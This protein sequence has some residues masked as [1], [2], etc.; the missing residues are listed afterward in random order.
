M[1]RDGFG[2]LVALRTRQWAS[3]ENRERQG[4]SEHFPRVRAV[5]ILIVAC[6]QHWPETARA[7]RALRGGRRTEFPPDRRACRA[8][9][10]AGALVAI[11][12]ARECAA[13]PF[14]SAAARSRIPIGGPARG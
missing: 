5:Q 12:A 9:I 1:R 13:P 8:A 6:K 3:G 4:P 14:S 11:S 10:G 7:P 2:G